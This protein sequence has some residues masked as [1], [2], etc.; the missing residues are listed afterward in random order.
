MGYLNIITLTEYWDW[1]KA[2]DLHYVAYVLGVFEFLALKVQLLGTILIVG[3][4]WQKLGTVAYKITD[5]RGCSPYNRFAYLER[6]ARSHAFRAIQTVQCVWS[7][8]ALLG[9]LVVLFTSGDTEDMA[10]ATR[11]ISTL[12]ILLI[13]IP[14]L[15]YECVIASKGRPKYKKVSDTLY[16]WNICHKLLRF[17]WPTLRI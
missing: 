15:I 16:R 5:A 2:R 3:D 11:F 10:F 7:Y 17:P 1:F 6:G 12:S 13:T 14:I 4:R 9:A 8:L